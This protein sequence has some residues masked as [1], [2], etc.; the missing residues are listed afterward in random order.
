MPKTG[1][2]FP[3]EGTLVVPIRLLLV[4]LVPTQ[5]PAANSQFSTL[6]YASHTK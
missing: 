4:L 6:D 2:E 3:D 1:N 5:I